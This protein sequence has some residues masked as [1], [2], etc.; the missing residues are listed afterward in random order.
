MPRGCRTDEGS[1]RWMLAEYNMVEHDSWAYPP[2]T[3]CNVVDSD[4][5]VLFGNVGSPG[6]KLTI[7]YCKQHGKPYII[8]PDAMGLRMWADSNGIET[9]NT[10]GN[11]EST[12]PGIYQSTIDTIVEAFK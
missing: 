12:N 8:N 2:R 1:K 5:T 10:A 11:R 3:E 6:C 7:R 4:G 9:M